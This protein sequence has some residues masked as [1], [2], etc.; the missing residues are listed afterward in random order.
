MY[1]LHFLTFI[2]IEYKY[3]KIQLIIFYIIKYISI[4]LRLEK[5]HLY[6]H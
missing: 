2:Q 4:Y 3:F 5:F 1:L 6:L